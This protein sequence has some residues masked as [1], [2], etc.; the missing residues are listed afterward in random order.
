[1]LYFSIAVNE[2]DSA[3]PRYGKLHIKDFFEE[4]GRKNVTEK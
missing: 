2:I 3:A 4:F 1:M